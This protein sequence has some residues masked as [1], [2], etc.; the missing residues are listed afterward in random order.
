MVTNRQKNVVI[1]EK[2]QRKK[3]NEPCAVHSKCS[4]FNTFCWNLPKNFTH[5]L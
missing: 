1:R 4:L 5:W 2:T 3:Q